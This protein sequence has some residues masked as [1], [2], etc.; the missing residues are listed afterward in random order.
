M[1]SSTRALFNELTSFNIKKG[2][3]KSVSGNFGQGINKESGSISSGRRIRTSSHSSSTSSFSSSSKVGS[4]KELDRADMDLDWRSTSRLRCSSGSSEESIKTKK[5]DDKLPNKVNR[6]D[7]DLNWRNHDDI[8][9]NSFIR[10]QRGNWRSENQRRQKMSESGTMSRKSL[11]SSSSNDEGSTVNGVNNKQEYTS[12]NEDP[13]NLS[14]V[15]QRSK[16]SNKVS[17][18]RSFR[19]VILNS[20]ES[21]REKDEASIKHA[22]DNSDAGKENV[23]SP[24]PTPSS[25]SSCSSLNSSPL[26]SS[27]SNN[28]MKGNTGR[29]YNRRSRK[30]KNKS[31]QSQT[32]NFPKK[33]NE[34]LTSND[35]LTGRHEKID[36]VPIG[37]MQESG[38]STNTLVVDTASFESVT[39]R[40]NKI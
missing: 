33:S 22:D 35:T 32:K 17:N 9:S 34:N 14:D 8:Q 31:H 37:M 12:K 5:R 16:P 18:G 3:K 38:I 15:T 36:N 24:S 30:T 2:I 29:E 25:L 23:F 1:G 40:N 11:E 20:K 26:L 39:S 10:S 13:S 27:S 28:L 19:D 6:A 7:R 21:K 4:R